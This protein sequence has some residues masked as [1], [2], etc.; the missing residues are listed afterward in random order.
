MAAG[1]QS[2]L[3]VLLQAASLLMMMVAMLSMS[4]TEAHSSPLQYNFY[5]KSCKNVEAIVF[6]K[7][8]EHY[9]TDKTVAPGVL[10]LMF[11]DAF[12]RVC[13]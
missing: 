6:Q 2:S 4:G 5:H 13:F 12:V 9:A 10:R 8:K 7:M 11:H 3:V 1:M